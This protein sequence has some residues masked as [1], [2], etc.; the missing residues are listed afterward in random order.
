LAASGWR[1]QREA[2]PERRLGVD[3]LRPRAATG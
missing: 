3:V 1:G 2:H